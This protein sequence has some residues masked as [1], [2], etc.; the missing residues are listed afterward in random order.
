M[1][2]NK[3]IGKVLSEMDIQA[4]RFVEMSKSGSYNISGVD[5]IMMKTEAAFDIAELLAGWAAT[6][7]D[8]LLEDE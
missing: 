4:G 6:L 2:M 3:R 1:M 7:R 5:V 8:E